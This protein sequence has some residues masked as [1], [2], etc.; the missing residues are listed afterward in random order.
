M[1]HQVYCLVLRP[2]GTHEEQDSDAVRLLAYPE[3]GFDYL[4]KA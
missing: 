3:A 1:T 4:Q 2:G